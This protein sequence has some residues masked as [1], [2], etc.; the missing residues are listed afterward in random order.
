MDQNNNESKRLYEMWR[1]EQALNVIQSP[2]EIEIVP[3]RKFRRSTA[4]VVGFVSVIVASV[5]TGAFVSAFFVYPLLNGALTD[6][7]I[8]SSSYSFTPHTPPTIAPTLGGSVPSISS[9]YGNPV[10][11]IAERCAGSVVGVMTKTTEKGKTTK[12]SRGTGFIITADGY[13]VTNF[14]VISTGSEMVVS[15]QDGKEYVAQ[16]IGGNSSLDVAVLK[17]EA[18]DLSAV[19]IGNSDETRVGELVVA[20]GNPAGANENLTGTVTVGYVSA[21]NR[22]LMF[23]QSRQRFIQT[24]AAINPG[25]SGGPLVNSVGQV[26]GINTL[27]SLVSSIGEDGVPINTEGIGFAIPINH[28]MET[29]KKIIMDEKK[30]GI[31]AYLYEVE[32]GDWKA[33]AGLLVHSFMQGSAAQ[34][35]GIMEGDIITACDGVTIRTMKDFS[36]CIEGKKVGDKISLTIFRSG[37][38]GNMEVELGNMNTMR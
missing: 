8:P 29:V 13:I 14:H 4:K 37:L 35:A 2:P 38:S 16:Y 11:E 3:K 19:P 17:I 12:L 24:D 25:N 15:M 36:G 22:E 5:M 18:K 23:N 34:K 9:K 6:E 20:I 1:K 33:P 27:K 7:P 21:V 32:E 30:P 28:A 31:G 26:I 10:P